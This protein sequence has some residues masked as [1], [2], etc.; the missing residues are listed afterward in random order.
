MYRIW[1]G[2]NPRMVLFAMHTGVSLIVLF[3]HLFAFKVVGYP[4]HVKAKYPQ[5][6]APAAAAPMR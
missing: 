3:I 2:L 1:I 6:F 4:D 5:Y